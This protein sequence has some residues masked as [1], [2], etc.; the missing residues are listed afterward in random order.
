MKNT[1]KIF[2]LLGIISEIN[3]T[4]VTTETL[5]DVSLVTTAPGQ[6]T[7]LPNGASTTTESDNKKE[8]H[9]ECNGCCVIS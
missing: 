9:S 5:E 2:I 1:L 6:P 3:A 4:E 8:K 7:P